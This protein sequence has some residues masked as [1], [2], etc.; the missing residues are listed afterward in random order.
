MAWVTTWVTTRRCVDYLS[1]TAWVTYRG[2]VS[3]TS[4]RSVG[5]NT[6]RHPKGIAVFNDPAIA[7]SWPN[8]VDRLDRT[9]RPTAW[10]IWAPALAGLVSVADLPDM[11]AEHVP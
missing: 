1:P 2:T 5:G 4:L 8:L 7:G 9:G 6:S 11:V 3:R 10:G